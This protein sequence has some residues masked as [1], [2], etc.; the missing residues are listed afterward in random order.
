MRQVVQCAKLTLVFHILGS[1]RTRLISIKLDRFNDP[2]IDE[3][4][5]RLSRATRK[6]RELVLFFLSQ[7]SKFACLIV[8]FCMIDLSLKVFVANNDVLIE[9]L[10]SEMNSQIQW[11]FD[12]SS[13]LPFTVCIL[14]CDWKIVR[15]YGFLTSSGKFRMPTFCKLRCDWLET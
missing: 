7:L 12:N 8:V 1:L 14:A 2:E 10:D 13:G 3:C 9:K 6:L 11:F 5:H 15:V 4:R